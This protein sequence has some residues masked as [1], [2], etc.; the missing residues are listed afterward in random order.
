MSRDGYSPD[1]LLT[2]FAIATR[3]Q[4]CK[5]M[6]GDAGQGGLRAGAGRPT[7]ASPGTNRRE[8]VP[9]GLAHGTRS[10]LLLGRANYPDRVIPSD[11]GSL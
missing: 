8:R 2:G 10:R 3:I 11:R 7:G 9:F 5:E 1:R 6:L 4:A